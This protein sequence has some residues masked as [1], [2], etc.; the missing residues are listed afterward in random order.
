MEHAKK[1]GARPGHSET[2]PALWWILGTM[3][4]KFYGQQRGLCLDY[5]ELSGLRLGWSGTETGKRSGPVSADERAFPLRGDSPMHG[6]GPQDY[7]LEEYI[8]YLK[9]FPQ[10]G[11]HLMIECVER[12]IRGVVTE[13]CEVYLP[14]ASWYT[15]SGNNVDGVIVTCRIGD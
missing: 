12:T 1:Y 8:D 9:Q 14:T 5:G 11:E 4:G 13:G 2:T 15:V 6:D 10:D 7:C 3:N